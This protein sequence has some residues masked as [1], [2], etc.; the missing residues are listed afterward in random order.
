MAEIAIPLLGLGAM[1]IISNKK[2]TPVPKEGFNNNSVFQSKNTSIINRKP[3]DRNYP[4]IKKQDITD[5]VKKYNGTKTGVEHYFNN[6]NYENLQQK[7]NNTHSSF[8][9]L[10]GSTVNPD[11]LEHNNMVPYFGSSVTQNTKNNQDNI[12][13]NYT[14]TGGQ[15]IKKQSVAPLFKNEKNL[16]HIYGAPNHNDFI[17]NRMSSNLTQKM[18]NVKPW[19]EEMVGP[20]LGKGY[21][22]GGNDGFNSGLNSREHYTP[23]DVDNLRVKTNP[24]M[25]YGGVTL[26]AYK[27]DL[28][29]NIMGK[30]EKNRPDT[31]YENDKLFTTTGIE[32]AQRARSTVILHPESRS[33]TTREYFG[34]GKSQNNTDSTYK[35]GE[36][37]KSH[38]QQLCSE[39]VGIAG[40]GALG[41]PN[42]MS[43]KEHQLLPNARSSTG[44]KTSMGFLSSQFQA[45]TAPLM[46]IMKFTRKSNVIG[47]ARPMGNA[48][49][50]NGV[51]NGVIWNPS[52]SLKTTI[53]EQTENNYYIKQGFTNKGGGYYSR[54]YQP[55]DTQRDTTS[56]AYTG[57]ADKGNGLKLYDADYNA[58]LNPNREVL[59]KVDRYNIGNHKLYNNHVNM[60]KVSNTATHEVQ[61]VPN[62]PK[63]NGSLQTFGELNNNPRERSINAESNYRNERMEH[64]GSAAKMAYQS[65]PYAHPIGSIA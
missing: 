56:V 17:Q 26:G 12:L 37:E 46:D 55:T 36:Y 2:P 44:V 61:C 19:K 5:T 59:S 15:K 53:K 63:I 31:W 40:A 49:G 65:N 28:G 43:K 29:Q 1:Y 39:N 57:G 10:N 64:I 8:L 38:K 22:T 16:S 21:N 33:S 45:L 47:N 24:K 35:V 48:S 32:K 50:K 3:I 25:T 23:K 60:T 52:D 58:R 4:V 41:N 9:S 54:V 30:M 62:M 51:S 20:G 18:N 14:G 6:T 34:V 7:S 13:E 27:P 11:D 42:D